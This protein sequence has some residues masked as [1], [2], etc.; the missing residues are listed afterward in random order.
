MAK[1]KSKGVLERIGDAVTTGAEA[2]MDAGSKAIDTVG[3]MLPTGKTPPKKA[4]RKAARAKSPKSSAGASKPEAKASKSQA[5]RATAEEEPRS[6]ASSSKA[7]G[8]A[9]KKA[10]AAK[11]AKPAG[12]AAARPKAS[13]KG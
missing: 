10:S 2:V 6:A 1:K 11:S 5:K 4:S 3:D 13:K 8:T 12:K 7:G 9:K